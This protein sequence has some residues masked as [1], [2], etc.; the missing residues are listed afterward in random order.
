MSMRNSK[1]ASVG[2]AE[3]RNEII[4]GEDEVQELGVVVKGWRTDSKGHCRPLK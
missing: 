1:D 4:R 2:E 3:L